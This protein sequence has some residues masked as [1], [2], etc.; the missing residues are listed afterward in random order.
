MA[1][2]R[3]ETASDRRDMSLNER[4]LIALDAIER[5]IVNAQRGI[6][7]TALRDLDDMQILGALEH[8]IKN[9][10]TEESGLIYEHPAAT[11]AIGELGRRI[12]S[13]IDEAG[14]NIPVDERPRRSEI[15][16]ALNFILES[17]KAHTQRSAGDPEATRSFM[18]YISLFTPWPE[19]V[20]RPLIL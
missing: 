2:R 19:E 12:R 14:K 11:P 13:G 16:K 6:G 3:R 17:V 1:L 4:G 8:T 18:R 5:A 10:E 15:L 7:G 20:A 9:R